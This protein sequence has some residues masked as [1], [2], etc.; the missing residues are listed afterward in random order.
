MILQTGKVKN[1]DSSRGYGFITTEDEEDLFVHLS[2]LHISV[3]NKRLFEG[4]QVKFDIRRDMKGDR[5][6]NVRLG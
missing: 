5:A 2:D 1:W 4:Q 6:I 3:K